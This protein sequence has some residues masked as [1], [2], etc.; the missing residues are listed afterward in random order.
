MSDGPAASSPRFLPLLY[1]SH[2]KAIHHPLIEVWNFVEHKRD[3]KIYGS[4]LSI[5]ISENP[6][7]G[8]KMKG[9]FP[10]VNRWRR[11]SNRS[12]DGDNQRSLP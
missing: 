4:Y 8:W 2:Q 10:N 1:L 5:N 7:S 9:F 6:M 3:K 12:V 11:T